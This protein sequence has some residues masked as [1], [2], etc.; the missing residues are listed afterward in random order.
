MSYDREDER[1]SGSGDGWSP[2]A[3]SPGIFVVAV[4]VVLLLGGVAVLNRRGAAAPPATA[5]A[6]ERPQ[7]GT[8]PTSQA[9]VPR[10]TATAVAPTPPPAEPRPT[11]RVFVVANTGGEGVF[12]RRTPRL[13]DRDTAYEDGTRLEQ[14][15][16]D[17]TA[18]GILW[19][20]V[21]APDGKTGFVP[22]QYTSES[23]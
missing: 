22:A 12:L 3:F 10:P 13:G 17:V 11:G 19:R 21:R 5:T 23:R 18:E 14:I 1:G 8:T 2:G 9:G 6:G 4:L 16:D 15:G 7:A 20:R